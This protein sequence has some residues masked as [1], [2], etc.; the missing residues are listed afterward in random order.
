MCNND[1]TGLPH[2]PFTAAFSLYLGEDLHESAAGLVADPH[3]VFGAERR[4]DGLQL[5]VD[6]LVR[7]R[8][9]SQ[10]GLA[11]R[12]QLEVSSQG[13]FSQALLVHEESANPLQSDLLYTALPCLG[14]L[15][16][17]YLIVFSPTMV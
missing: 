3:F 7:E 9:D 15:A 5:S 12:V 14:Y 6:R 2:V 8:L 16:G 10:L 4:A 13:G 11:G 1:Y 17:Y